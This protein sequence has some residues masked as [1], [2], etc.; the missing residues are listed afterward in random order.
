MTFGLVGVFAFGIVFVPLALVFGTVA[1]LRGQW[2][3][4]FIGLALA[5]FGFLTSPTLM[6]LVGLGA[7]AWFFHLHAPMPPPPGIAV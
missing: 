3:L 1:V 2:A 5:V 4:G 7:V 6:A